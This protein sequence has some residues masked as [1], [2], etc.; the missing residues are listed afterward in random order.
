MSE[1]HPPFPNKTH[2]LKGDV[3]KQRA[4]L[5]QP[6]PL[7]P[8]EEAVVFRRHAGQAVVAGVPASGLGRRERGRDGGADHGVDR[9]SERSH[10]ADRGD[11]VDR[12]QARQLAVEELGLRVGVR[13]PGGGGPRVGRGRGHHGGLWRGQYRGLDLGLGHGR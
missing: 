10:G 5:V 8:L 2:L 4:V 1:A 12:P 6:K 9:G 11:E 13:V 3:L 7:E